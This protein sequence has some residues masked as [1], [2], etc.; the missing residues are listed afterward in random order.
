MRYRVPWLAALLSLT[1]LAAACGDP[2][3][4][5]GD[6][7]LTPVAG[8]YDE[9]PSRARGIAVE[10][11]RIG[12][13][14]VYADRIDPD[15]THSE[16][17]GVV[18]GVRGVNDMLSGAQRMALDPFDVLAGFGAIGS[19][20]VS[21]DEQREKYLS[22]V[23]VAL[24]DEAQADAAAR[25]MAAADFEANLA[26]AP[27]P[28]PEF[29]AALSHW[30]PG[31]P[32][33]GSWLVWKNLVIRV[34]AK[35]LEPRAE[36][37]TDLLTRTYRAQLA[38]LDTFVP[39]PA[40][41]VANLQMDAD[42][43]LTKVVKTGDH[44]PDRW[45]FM[46]YGARSFAL[47]LDRP[48]DRLREFEEAQISAVAVSYDKFLH[49][50]GDSAAARTFAEREEEALLADDYTVTSAAVSKL[51][52]VSCY[53]AGRPKTTVDAPRRFACLVRHNEFVV[54]MYGNQ[55]SDLWQQAAAQYALLG[56]TW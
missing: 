18:A 2:A 44:W 48:A 33:V 51:D 28:V 31:V 47:L 24:P 7:A 29:P 25:A 52:G 38:E 6:Y 15:L 27:L 1:L 10:S 42:A 30:R 20:G 34:F 5:H 8:E 12:E 14:L 46:V 21:G 50:A 32:T 11:V 3:L 36:V 54:R 40:A 23:I 45:D 39:T 35:V 49:R 26:N 53:R 56:G 37:L 41:E 4:D 22:I 17:G 9:V 16:G 19:N 13:R 55:E 43:L